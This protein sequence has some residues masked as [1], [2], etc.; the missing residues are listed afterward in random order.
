MYTNDQIDKYMEE[1]LEQAR[2][3]FSNNEVPV[4]AIIVKDNKIIG[5]GFNKRENNLDISSHA[6]IEAMKDAANYLGTWKLEGCS[7]FVTLEPCLMCAGAIE[8]SGLVSL[9]FGAEDKE[10]GAIVNNECIGSKIGFPLVYKN[11][12]SAECKLIL[13]EFFKLIRSQK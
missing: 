11:I 4:G 6:E 3:A 10:K 8:Q 5:R 1:A 7:L 9:Y 13:K 2:V 12:K